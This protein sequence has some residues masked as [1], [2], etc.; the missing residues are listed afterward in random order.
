MQFL[1]YIIFLF[2]FSL[3]SFMSHDLLPFFSLYT[4]FIPSSVVKEAFD[5]NVTAEVFLM[6]SVVTA[7]NLTYLL[8]SCM[9]SN[10]CCRTN[11]LCFA[12][13]Q[14]IEM[15]YTIFW[16]IFGFMPFMISVHKLWPTFWVFMLPSF[17]T[18]LLQFLLS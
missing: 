5:L 14:Y 17:Y 8:Q 13:N 4:T 11:C 18:N 6:L 15:C 10:D 2:S 1:L 12:N 3:V 16:L 9:Y 7:E